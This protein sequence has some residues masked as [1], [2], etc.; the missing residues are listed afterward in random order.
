MSIFGMAMSLPCSQTPQLS[1]AVLP[2]LLWYL[3]HL[4]LQA[5]RSLRSLNYR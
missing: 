2:H 1:G 5:R 4:E 3:L